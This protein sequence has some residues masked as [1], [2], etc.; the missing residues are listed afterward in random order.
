M[1]S[2]CEFYFKKYVWSKF[3]S[4][5]RA[6]LILLWGKF[7]DF[8]VLCIC[9]MTNPIESESSNSTAKQCEIEIEL[10]Q[11]LIIICFTRGCQKSI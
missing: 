10:H 11:N 6:I 9:Y 7:P 4:L 8:I 5:C 2:G 3:C 1:I